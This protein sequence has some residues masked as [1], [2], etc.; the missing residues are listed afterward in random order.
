MINVV[1][2]VDLTRI[3]K[4]FNP[5][6]QPKRITRKVLHDSLSKVLED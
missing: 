5:S 3:I 6:R 4:V 2:R 1:N